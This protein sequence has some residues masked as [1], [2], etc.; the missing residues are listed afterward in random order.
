MLVNK[1]KELI[2]NLSHEEKD[3][4][5][6]MC[7]SIIVNPVVHIIY[8]RGVQ[9]KRCDGN[10]IFCVTHITIYYPR[11][12]ETC[13]L[14]DRIIAVRAH[15]AEDELSRLRHPDTNNTNNTTGG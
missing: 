13:P 11:E 8:E 12:E 15:L 4:I 3:K 2:E 10:S 6:E 9:L 14:C 1:Y 7:K 5:M